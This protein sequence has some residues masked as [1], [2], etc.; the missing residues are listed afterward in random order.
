MDVI[1][2]AKSKRE[3]LLKE[4]RRLD[5]FIKM[6]ES[7]DAEL[8]P[9]VGSGNVIVPSAGR[10]PGKKL[11]NRVRVLTAVADLIKKH[12]PMKKRD[13]FKH[14]QEMGIDPGTSRPSVMLS[15]FLSKSDVFTTDKG[16]WRFAK[17]KGPAGVNQ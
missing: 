9:I 14:L 11:S 13:L 10:K 16:M 17:G 5:D 8:Q 2:R 3:T 7:L 1:E 6:A 15:I 4:L 12:G